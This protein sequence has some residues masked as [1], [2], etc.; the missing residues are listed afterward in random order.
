MD[1]KLNQHNLYEFPLKVHCP[2]RNTFKE[3]KGIIDTGSEYCAATYKVI[4]T[5]KTR[6]IDF[7]LISA[8]LS[9][10]RC[11]VYN[12]KFEFDNQSAFTQVARVTHLP[13]GI[14]FLIGQSF[15]QM[16]NYSKQDKKFTLDWK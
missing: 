8:P 3:L 5:L 10:K 13:D 15:L 11:L 9:Q 4:V 6:P 1:A 16:C 7:R 14:D 2:I 12:V